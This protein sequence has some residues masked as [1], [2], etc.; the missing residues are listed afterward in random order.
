MTEN[1][2]LPF[3]YTIIALLIWA[4]TAT[5]APSQP[6]EP[7]SLHGSK[8]TYR[9]FS[10]VALDVD[11]ALKEQGIEIESCT[12]QS[13]AQRKSISYRG[14]GPCLFQGFGES[15]GSN[16]LSGTIFAWGKTPWGP[17]NGLR[18]EW[19]PVEGGWGA[20]LRSW[21]DLQLEPWF[22]WRKSTRTLSSQSLLGEIKLYFPDNF[23][24][25]LLAMSSRPIRRKDG[26]LEFEGRLAISS[27]K[28]HLEN[29]E[30]TWET[31]AN[32]IRLKRHFFLH[33]HTAV[34]E[35]AKP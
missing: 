13:L 18:I 4:T 10:W 31:N 29:T 28:N 27:E 12:Y 30:V 17:L 16:N 6:S 7:T 14:L 11:T 19:R 24:V 9:F 23:P 21:F 1:K 3:L 22:K 15:M 8:W 26:V 25:Q 2:P 5:G 32:P 35:E 20:A 33:A 34:L